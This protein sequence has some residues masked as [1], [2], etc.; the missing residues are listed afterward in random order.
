[1]TRRKDKFNVNDENGQAMEVGNGEEANVDPDNRGQWSNQCEFFL[2]CLAYSVGF[3]N[4]WRFPYLCYKNGGVA[5]GQYVSLG[6]NILFPKLCPLTGG[7]FLIPYTIMLLVAGIPLF[8]MELALGQYVSLGP[9]IL[10]PKLCPL[11]GGCYTFE[12]NAL[13]RDASM[14]YYAGECHNTDT[15]CGIDSLEAVNSTHCL[16]ANNISIRAEL[17]VKRYSAAE[18]YY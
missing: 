17:A 5:L 16:T 3:G 15:F 4:I 1:M 14:Y 6:P 13:C 2:S 7:E 10:F 18:D 8:F 12:E 9:N 11:T